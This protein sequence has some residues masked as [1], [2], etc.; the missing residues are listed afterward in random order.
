MFINFYRLLRKLFRIPNAT[1][2]LIKSAMATR[3]LT[4]R[5]FPLNVRILD[6]GLQC[7]IQ[8]A[9]SAKVHFRGTLS[10]G[11]WLGHADF[12]YIYVGPGGTFELDGDFHLGSGSRIHIGENAKLYIGGCQ[13]ESASGIT[14]DAII[15]C[16]KSISMGKDFL[17]AWG[18]FITDSDH[19]RYGANNPPIEVFI[20]DHVWMCPN[21]SI[22]KGSRVGSNSVIAQGSVVQKNSFPDKSLI[23]GNPA[24]RIAEAKDW[25]R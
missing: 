2:R 10:I 14:E 17:G 18:L 12:V 3:K 25:H 16:Q 15:L 20:G 13:N 6:S 22:L 21:S 23:G 1:I 8:K 19:H 11:G 9:K 24:T 7:T 5:F 4:G